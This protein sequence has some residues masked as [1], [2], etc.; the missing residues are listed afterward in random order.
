MRL[1]LCAEPGDQVPLD[2]Y[3]MLVHHILA[4]EWPSDVIHSEE[5]V[6]VDYTYVGAIL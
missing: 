2:W 4:K 6:T 1:N 5:I 3:L